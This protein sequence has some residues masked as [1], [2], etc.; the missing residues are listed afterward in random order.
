MLHNSS[1]LLSRLFYIYITS[2]ITGGVS[3]CIEAAALQA[4]SAEEFAQKLVLWEPKP[5]EFTNGLVVH[6]RGVRACT[7]GTELTVWEGC[8]KT[9]MV[10]KMDVRF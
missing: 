3:G 4:D 8:H 7:H 1:F 2:Y 10:Q 5:E 6:A 9:N